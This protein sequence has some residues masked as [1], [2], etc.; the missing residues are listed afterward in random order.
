MSGK[1]YIYNS[2]TRTA[3]VT[4]VVSVLYTHKQ[5]LLRMCFNL[6]LRIL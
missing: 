4:A 3:I 6:L 1:Q 2:F 5:E